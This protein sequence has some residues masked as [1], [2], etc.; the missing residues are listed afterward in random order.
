MPN[1]MSPILEQQEFSLTNFLEGKTQAW[2]IFEDRFGK[3]KLR[4]AVEMNGSWSGDTFILLEDFDYDDGRKE[5][6]EW[7]VKPGENGYFT[8]TC[9]DCIGQAVGQTDNNEIQMRYR[10]RL[11]L[12]KR[13]LDVDFLDRLIKVDEQRVVNR[14]IMSKW[15]IKLGELSLFFEKVSDS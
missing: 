9:D 14:A 2:G 13:T 8:A 15:G 4:F 12:K 11:K 5:K 6:R 3:V 10:F 1:D 7:H